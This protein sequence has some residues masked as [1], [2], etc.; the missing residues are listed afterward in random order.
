MSLEKGVRSVKGHLGTWGQHYFYQ[1]ACMYF[2]ILT[3][4]ITV[5]RHVL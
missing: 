5:L 4:F 3:T 2:N 1:Q